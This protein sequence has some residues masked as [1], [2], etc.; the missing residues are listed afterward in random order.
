MFTSDR[1]G[2]CSDGKFRR[3]DRPSRQSSDRDECKYPN[4]L[5]LQ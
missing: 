4:S 1:D 2:K 3:L 5:D